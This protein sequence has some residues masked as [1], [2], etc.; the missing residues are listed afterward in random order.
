MTV[1]GYSP[2]VGVEIA[3][4][5]NGK[6]IFDA[7]LTPSTTDHTDFG[8]VAGGAPVSRTYTVHNYGSE[9]L[10][11]YGTA[12]NYVPLSTC[13]SEFSV[14]AQ[15]STPV[16]AL[17]GTTTFT[18]Q[19]SPS[20]AGTDTCQVRI[21]NADTDEGMFVYE[22]T[23]TGTAT[24]EINL[25]G[26]G[27]SITDGD[28][29]PSTTD[30]TD[31]DSTEVTTGTVDR[32]YTVQNIG[33]GALNL[34]LPVLVGGANAAD[35][36]V[37]TAPTA[38]VAVSGNTTFTVRF[39]PSAIGTRSATISLTNNDSNENPYNFAIQGTGTDPDT[40]SDGV[41]NSI[42]T[43]DD[44]DGV[45]DTSDAF[46]LNATE[47]V[48][49]DNDGTGNNA[50][51]DDDND[52]V[53]DTS[54]AFPLNAS[55]SV[56]TDNDGT[57]NNADTDDDND[58]VLDTSDAFPLNAS[59]SVDTDSDG[60][61]NNADT[62]DDNDSVLDAS[63][64]FPLDVTES[65]D[66]DNDGTGNNADT[67]DDGDGLSDANEALVGTNPLLTDSN[68]NGTS[69][70][71]EDSD[72]DGVNNLAEQTKG[73]N[74]SLADT[75]SDGV[76]DANDA[77]PLNPSESVDT[78]NDGTGNNA[79]TDDDGD[80]VL[81]TSD[82]FPLDPNE[83]VDTDSDG[84]GNN[85]DTDDDNDS[86]LDTSDAFPLDPNESVDT[87]SDG[88]GNNADTDDDND[89]VLDTSDA[90]PLDATESVDTDNDGTGNNA[91][92]DDDGDGL[93]DANEAL[94]GTDPL[95]DDS[96]SDGTSDAS[97]D[98]DG[99][100]VNNLTEQQAGT[101]LLLGDSDGDG[102]ADNA[103]DSDGDGLS[104]QT[105]QAR[106]TNPGLSDTD[107]D[108]VNDSS[109][110]FPLD[111]TRSSV[112]P[113]PPVY[114]YPE[115][116]LLDNTTDIP[117]NSGKLDFGKTPVGTPVVKTLTLKNTGR[118]TLTL[119]TPTLSTGFSVVNF[120]TSIAA[121]KSVQFTLNLDAT[122][123]ATL[124][125]QFSVTNNDG[126]ENPFN[127]T[128]Q[129]IVE[130]LPPVSV[131][132]NVSYTGLG[133]ITGQGIN[134]GTDCTEALPIGTQLPGLS[135]TPA[136]G[137]VFSGWNNPACGTGLTLN[138]DTACIATFTDNTPPT[139]VTTAT[140]TV[141]LV[142]QGS[143]SGLG[144]ACGA[145]C[146]ETVNVGT[147]IPGLS[148]TPASGYQFAH[149]NNP[150]C[151][152]GFTLTGHTEC[153]ATFTD[154]PQPV[155]T[156]T[157]TVRL[158]GQGSV[159]GTGINC[160]TDCTESLAVGSQIAGLSA[161][162]ANGYQFTSWNN[163]ACGT[164][165]NLNADTECVA[166]FSQTPLDLD[167]DQDGVND[168]EE[169][170][171]GVDPNTFAPAGV[172]CADMQ[173]IN[174]GQVQQPSLVNPCLAAWVTRNQQLPQRPADYCS[175]HGEGLCLDPLGFMTTPDNLALH[176][177]SKV[178]ENHQGQTAV[179]VLAIAFSRDGAPVRF[180]DGQH[181]QVLGVSLTDLYS[182]LPSFKQIGQLG[183]ALGY[184]L[185]LSLPI[186]DYIL[187]SAY[188]LQDGTLSFGSSPIAIRIGLPLATLAEPGE[189]LYQHNSARIGIQVKQGDNGLPNQL[190][191]HIM[192]LQAHL[193]AKVAAKHFIL[194]L[195]D[196]SQLYLL[197]AQY[198]WKNWNP[199]FEQMYQDVT[200][201]LSF[202][203]VRPIRFSL[204][205]PSLPTD[206]WI[207][208]GYV[209][210]DNTVVYSSWPVGVVKAN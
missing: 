46:P 153:V 39:S 15:A 196:D 142:G 101:N 160:G 66:T 140:L 135:A 180:F 16:A 162:P 198:Q 175:D 37:T 136:T 114:Y 111:P 141:R 73:T 104:N 49:T 209:L 25:Q 6:Q 43:D 9:P 152:S 35:F 88:T 55:E 109:D 128:L 10:S 170:T 138:A 59:E 207:Y 127:F 174:L 38:S 77:L 44:N 201:Y 20:D 107:G 131:S 95:L 30:H 86:V 133:N 62:D 203:T 68:N 200:A 82:A 137:Q 72:S 164:G 145:D 12:P 1:V 60:T 158:V 205:I 148:A 126:N 61:G 113:P 70:A 191:G 130:I 81:D 36:T 117:D 192:P 56:D 120:P 163:P 183:S 50:D 168:A 41:T 165:F 122:Q 92:T 154:S 21:S 108:S 27:V 147:Q 144:I 31:F 208:T 42:D 186:G 34:T 33:S 32:T 123:A 29:T 182:Q 139:P 202:D 99:D 193:D 185:P 91:D 188:A 90:L 87:D 69:D 181:W 116:Q 74:P 195:G 156:A 71:S 161:T 169:L 54:D 22:I 194:L 159:S 172:L 176:V 26:N 78:D 206:G 119:G 75:D 179:K 171:N 17:G 103:E 197:N 45:L 124:S 65:V 177:R 204:S 83:S 4:S 102:I 40:D 157:L 80:S 94:V 134:C 79:D 132:L 178:S 58:S 106:G 67:D 143:V 93:S 76:N 151:G 85:A 11:L 100:G 125:G 64:A 189:A 48:D 112:P 167:T 129:G 118:A 155:T 184:D 166:S 24:P 51:T 84:T 5:G 115:I 190:Q 18:V 187:Y 28:A 173:A 121:G 149:W 96:D 146:A 89:S 13:G 97:E 63:D 110:A 7:D 2:P 8:T 210:P 19:Y 98:S 105:E 14:T 57:G 53:L 150:A 199:S 52:G 23:A 3:V 47:S